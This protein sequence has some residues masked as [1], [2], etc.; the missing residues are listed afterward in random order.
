MRYIFLCI[1]SF[2][3]IIKY[4]I[5]IYLDGNKKYQLSNQSIINENKL[6]TT[7]NRKIFPPSLFHVLLTISKYALFW[8]RNF[9]VTYINIFIYDKQVNSFT[10][11]ANQ[12]I[13]SIK[14]FVFGSW[15]LKQIKRFVMFSCK[16]THTITERKT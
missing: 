1:P 7:V 3:S 11:I 12:V 16:N 2:F 8:N 5:C 15:M 6:S 10:C 4:C 9:S 13:K 14:S